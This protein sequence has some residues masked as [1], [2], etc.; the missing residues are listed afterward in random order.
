[1][2]VL[3]HEKLCAANTYTV[4]NIKNVLEELDVVDRSGQTVVP[5]MAGTVVIR[6]PTRPTKLAVFQ[7]T[8]TRIKQAADFGF[9]SFVGCMRGHLHH[10]P[11]LNFFGTEDPKLNP[12]NR[13]NF[14]T[15]SNESSWHGLFLLGDFRNKN[16][17]LKFTWLWV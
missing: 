10:G 12:Y 3:V 14:R 11:T 17:S 4:E 1:V 15:W 7:Y 2:E 8:H 13:F 9:R 16:F 6:L 5:K